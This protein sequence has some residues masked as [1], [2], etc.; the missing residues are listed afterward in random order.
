MTTDIAAEKKCPVLGLLV[1][2]CLLAGASADE[3]KVP[4]TLVDSSV[5]SLLSADLEQREAALKALKAAGPQR[6]N[7]VMARLR[8]SLSAADGAVRV[9]CA[10]M[11]WNLEG[12]ADEVL[13]VFR[14]ALNDPSRE[15]RSAALFALGDMGAA[16]REA[17]PAI[18]PLLQSPSARLRCHAAYNL[19]KIDPKSNRPLAALRRVLEERDEEAW[20]DVFDLVSMLGGAGRDLAPVLIRLLEDRDQNVR[21]NA[22]VTLGEIHPEPKLAVPALHKAL[23]D[24]NSFVRG[25]AAIALAKMGDKGREKLAALRAL[26]KDDNPLVRVQ[27][28]V[29]VWRLDHD[30]AAAVPVLTKALAHDKYTMANVAAVQALGEIGPGAKA[31]EPALLACRKKVEGDWHRQAIAEAVRK[32]DP[33]SLPEAKE[34]P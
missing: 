32:I 8:L 9:R 30:D 4:D 29:A 1:T 12:K 16:A 20:A 19:W 14:K 22:V 17:V 11:V 31:A 5:E 7:A 6:R 25:T 23:S 33:K 3:P 15:V 28:A 10:Q 24:R 21:N 18:E 27:A 26:M 13:P 34:R 2:L